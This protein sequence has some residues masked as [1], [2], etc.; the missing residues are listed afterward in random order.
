[1]KSEFPFCVFVVD[2]DPFCRQLYEYNLKKLGVKDVYVFEN[3]EDCINSL[4][5]EPD[6]IL[7]DHYMKPLSGLDVME[8]IK[9]YSPDIFVVIISGQEEIILPVLAMESGAFDYIVKSDVTEERFLEVIEK[10]QAIR[11]LPK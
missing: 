10:I 6:L 8:S 9:N 2:D 4:V 7:L 5:L 1:M 11:Q 3:G